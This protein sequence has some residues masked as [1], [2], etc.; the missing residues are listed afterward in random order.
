MLRYKRQIKT[1]NRGNKMKANKTNCSKYI[2]TGETTDYSMFISPIHQRK[3]TDSSVKA[4]MSSIQEHGVIASISCRASVKF[5]RKLETYDGQHTIQACKRLGVPVVYNVFGDVS[6][7]AMISLNGKT[8]TWNMEAYLHYGVVDNID[9]YC[10][11]ESIYKE[12][13]VPLT[14]LLLMYGGGYANKSFK[15]LTWKALT[16]NR[17]NKILGY[18]KDFGKV[19][20]IEHSRHARFIWGLC[21]VMDTGLYNHDRMMEQLSKCSQLMTKQANPEGYAKNIELVYN[22]GVTVKN[23]VQFVQ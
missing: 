14:G 20:K 3:K 6:N 10:F 4:I 17:G 7:K 12:E 8:R 23:R 13:K 19:Y 5:P 22:H 2:R 21:K 11:I 16:V 9:D 18:L 1:N 15:D